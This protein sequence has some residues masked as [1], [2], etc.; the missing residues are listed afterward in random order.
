MCARV[1]TG[2]CVCKYVCAGVYADVWKCVCMWKLEDYLWYLSQWYFHL[3]F[4]DTGSLTEPDTQF[5]QTC[6]P[7][8]PGYPPVS[9][10]LPWHWSH[11]EPLHPAFT[12]SWGSELWS[13][14]LCSEHFTNSFTSPIFFLSRSYCV[15]LAGLNS[16]CAPDWPLT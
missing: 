1:C 6:W 7:I 3:S 2:M 14:L 12:W 11:V 8:S 9:L 16:L 10:W 5:S 4:S 15:A 13:L